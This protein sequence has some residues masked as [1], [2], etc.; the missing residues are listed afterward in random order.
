[1]RFPPTAQRILAL[2]RNLRIIPTPITLLLQLHLILIY[3]LAFF[4]N[5]SVISFAL[6]RTGSSLADTVEEEGCEK[7]GARC[8]TA[9]VDGEFGCLG[10]GL[11]FL[12]G[13]EGGDLGFEYSVHCC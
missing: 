8:A 12:G 10:K 6:E 11:E 1:M 13:R 4:F 7:D 2:I 9:T 3:V 5:F